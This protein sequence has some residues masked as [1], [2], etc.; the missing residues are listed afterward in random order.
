[1]TDLQMNL[2]N[3]SLFIGTLVVALPTLFTIIFSWF[4]F[5]KFKSTSI[6][7]SSFM[8]S[9]MIILATFGFMREAF[10]GLD[11][12]HVHEHHNL[13]SSDHDHSGSYSL[14]IIVAII[15]GGCI[16]GLLISILTRLVVSKFAKETHI[17]HHH[18]NH[19]D[20]LYNTNDIETKSSFVVVIWSLLAHKIVAGLSLAMTVYDSNSLWGFENLGMIIILIVHMI[21]ES[22]MIFHK[23]N[24]IF[25][26]KTKALMLSFGLQFVIIIF[27]IIGIFI[28]NALTTTNWVMPF[29]YALAGASMMF[30]S[31][32]DLVPE[33]IHNKNMSKKQW[34]LTIIVFSL[35]LLFGVAMCLLH[36]H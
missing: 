13:L 8:A 25:K 3:N 34:F 14:G 7:I 9:M 21:P 2:L 26:S 27:M 6:Y 24:E 12:G 22:I 36:S 19:S 35:G 17:N 23:A 15:M 32:F 30:S 5:D 1:M 29:L 10:L 18:H 31:I 11:G 16:G 28:F 33:F 4:R 20:I